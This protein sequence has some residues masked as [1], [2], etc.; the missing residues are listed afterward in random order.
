MLS[1]P[2]YA[3]IEYNDLIQDLGCDSVVC[4]GN[5]MNRGSVFDLS[6]LFEIRVGEEKHAYL[7]FGGLD[8]MYLSEKQVEDIMEGEWTEMV[9]A[10]LDLFPKF[11][12]E[13][14]GN[15]VRDVQSLS[16]PIF[17]GVARVFSGVARK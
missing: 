9:G 10:P 3:V 11:L 7:L 17:P 15:A 13:P 6:V 8:L 1:T 12:L 2:E 16:D 4:F 14:L 5:Y